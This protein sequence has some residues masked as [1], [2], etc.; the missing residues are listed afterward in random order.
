MIL[1]IDLLKYADKDRSVLSLKKKTL[2]NGRS[3]DLFKISLLTIT[4]FSFDIFFDRQP[5]NISDQTLR[6]FSS[7]K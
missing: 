5:K 3:F 4:S 6:N 7:M 1:K 2:T